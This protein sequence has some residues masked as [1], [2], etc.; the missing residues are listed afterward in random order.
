MALAG[1][2]RPTQRI[3][4]CKGIEQS[5]KLE[6]DRAHAM[7]EDYKVVRHMPWS[8]LAGGTTSTKAK[9]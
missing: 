4:K 8:R 7:L 6:G 5:S 1:G 9:D 2:K 3:S